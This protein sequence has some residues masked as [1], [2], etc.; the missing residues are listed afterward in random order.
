MK[1]DY[2]KAD[3]QTRLS[4]YDKKAIYEELKL[5]ELEIRKTLYYT[6]I[7]KFDL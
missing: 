4:H 1:K 5:K 7:L 2:D 6:F 3:I